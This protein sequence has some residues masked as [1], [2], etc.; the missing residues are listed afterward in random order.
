MAAILNIGNFIE[1]PIRLEINNGGKPAI[2]NFTLTAKRIDSAEW[3]RWFDDGE[4]KDESVSE[5]L[6]EHVTAWSKQTLIIDSETNQPVEFSREN[7]AMMLTV[8]GVP[9]DPCATI[10]TPGSRNCCMAALMT[11]SSFCCCC[12]G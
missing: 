7:F 9:R 2:F 1:L 4:K 12:W 8:L 6:L 3:T 10:N 5:F 11:I